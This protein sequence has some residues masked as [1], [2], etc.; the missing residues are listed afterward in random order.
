M[1]EHTV[2]S[3][4]SVYNADINTAGT[5]ICRDDS[6]NYWSVFKDLDNNIAIYKSTNSGVTW[7]LMKTLSSSDF[8][9]LTMPVDSFSI[10]H[11]V[12]QNKVYIFLEKR[13]TLANKCWGWVINT[14]TDVGSVDL[15]NDDLYLANTLYTIYKPEIR[16]DSYNNKLYVGYG[17]NGITAECFYHEIKLDGT[18][19]T[20]N[21]VTTLNPA[22]QGSFAIDSNGNKF[23]TGYSNAGAYTAIFKNTGSTHKH[24]AYY[25]TG[26]TY[27]FMGTICDYDNKVVFGFVIGTVFHTYRADNNLTTFELDDSQVDLGAGHTPTIAFLTVDGLGNIYWFYTDSYDNEAYYI[28]YNVTTATWGSSIKI[29]SDNDGKL[30]CPELR[31]PIDKT[32]LLVTYQAVA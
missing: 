17:H 10:A 11:L 23:F 5:W 29:S 24:T 22:Y 30:V 1:S 15:D 3:N 6:G 28:K 18:L 26:I 20:V 27:L 32:Q 25:G 9:S 12:G 19:G 14:L 2:G 16:W 4:A 13:G 7:T 31:C 21:H 8:T